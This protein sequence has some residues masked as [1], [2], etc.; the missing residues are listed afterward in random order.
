MQKPSRRSKSPDNRPARARYW[1][2]GQLRKHKVAHIMKS[3]GLSRAE[4][5]R[6]WESQRKGRMKAAH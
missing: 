6:Q 1:N 2:T 3:A 5:L 4:A